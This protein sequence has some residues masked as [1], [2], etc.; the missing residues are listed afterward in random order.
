[1]RGSSLNSCRIRKRFS[2]I[3]SV[4]NLMPMRPA[5]NCAQPGCPEL[6]SQ[7]TRCPRHQLPRAAREVPRPTATQRGYGSQWSRLRAQYLAAH[8]YCADPFNHHPHTLVGGQVVDHIRPRAL[9]GADAN[10]N[11]QTLCQACHNYKT[12]HDGSRNQRGRKCFQPGGA[13]GGA[14]TRTRP[15]NSQ[16]PKNGQSNTRSKNF[17]RRK[18]RPRVSR[19]RLWLRCQAR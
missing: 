19:G 12:A 5:R 10:S 16:K 1:M 2:E 14:V 3:W 6:V 11:L 7:G 9:G 8:P 15:R 13:T 17:S 4:N 18:R